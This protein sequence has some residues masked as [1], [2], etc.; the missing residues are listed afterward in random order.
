MIKLRRSIASTSRKRL[1]TLIAGHEA[2]RS[3]TGLRH[4]KS[5]RLQW[6]GAAAAVSAMMKPVRKPRPYFSAEQLKEIATAKYAEA[7]TTPEGPDRQ[8]ILKEARS[9]Q[10][11]AMIKR[12]L[13]S[14]L[15]QRSNR[16]YH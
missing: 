10:S 15:R 1:T 14:Q 11:R 7:A 4:T 2:A 12:W 9:F 16:T 8:K 3:P 6:E 5:D 13:T